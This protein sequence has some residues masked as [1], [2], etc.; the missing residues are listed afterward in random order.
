MRSILVLVAGLLAGIASD[1]YAQVW[2]KS[3]P[4]KTIYEEVDLEQMI[5]R[6]FGKEVQ[7]V[8]SIEGIYSVTCIITKKGYNLFTG[9][10][11]ERIIERKENYARVAILKDWPGSNRDF[12]EVSMSYHLAN[13]YPIVGTFE[14]MLEGGGYVYTHIEPDGEKLNFTM[15]YDNMD[16]IE[17][18]FSKVQRRKTITYN[19]SYMKIYP[20]ANEL[21]VL[22]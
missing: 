20:K 7:T 1:A 2:F 5:R 13:K 16:M 21:N 10:E 4:K 19:L 9:Q 12:I 17:G 8:S 15:L 14:V 22:R 18:E 11:Q 3:R 6:Y